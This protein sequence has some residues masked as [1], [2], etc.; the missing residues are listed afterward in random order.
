MCVE[1]LIIK[2]KMLYNIQG[3]SGE[4]IFSGI[5][6]ISEPIIYIAVLLKT[7]GLYTFEIN[8][9]I[10]SKQGSGVPE[11][12]VIKNISVLSPNIYTLKY[13]STEP[14]AIYELNFANICL[15]VSTEC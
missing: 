9:E 5:G 6:F 14:L 1:K 12:Y 10:T 15:C 3:T 4:I 13:T 8:N 11:F 2:E 7:T